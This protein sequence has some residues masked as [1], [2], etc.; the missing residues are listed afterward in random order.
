MALALREATYERGMAAGDEQN[1]LAPAAGGAVGGAGNQIGEEMSDQV[2]PDPATDTLEGLE[3]VDKEDAARWAYEMV[4]QGRSAKEVSKKIRALPSAAP[5]WQ[6]A[7]IW[8]NAILI[9]DTAPLC[10]VVGKQYVDPVALVQ[11]MNAALEDMLASLPA[12]PKST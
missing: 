3:L 7:D 5:Q 4:M 6:P 12:P 2:K 10:H 8:R 1:D 11:R 9:V